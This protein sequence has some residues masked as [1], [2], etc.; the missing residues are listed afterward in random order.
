M[1]VLNPQMSVLKCRSVK[2][3][4]QVSYK[5]IIDISEDGSSLED[6]QKEQK[7]QNGFKKCFQTDEII[8]FYHNKLSSLSIQLQKQNVSFF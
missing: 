3:G 4:P 1:L 6:E 2:V 8:K 5:Q 7:H